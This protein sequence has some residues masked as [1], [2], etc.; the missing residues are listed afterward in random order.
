MKLAFL[1]AAWRRRALTDLT[2]RRFARM[3]ERSGHLADIELVCAGS[4]RGESRTAAERHGWHYVEYPNSPLGRKWNA[5]LAS[6]KALDPDAVVIVGT[7]DWITDTL[8]PEYVRSLE[9]GAP[10]I[11]FVDLY[12][13]RSRDLKAIRWKGYRHVS[14]TTHRAAEPVGC[15]RCLDRRTLESVG[16]TLWES[17]LER[18]LDGAAF[19]ALLE[20]HPGLLERARIGTMAELGLKAVDIKSGRNLSRWDSYFRTPSAAVEVSVDEVLGGFPSDEVSDLIGFLRG[21]RP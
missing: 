12:V 3:R 19:N 13:M 7:D 9:A 15:G 14:H 4:E 20:R 2:L 11:G 18:G 10:F 16:W 8:V 1:T 6:A 5:A 21:R 17:R